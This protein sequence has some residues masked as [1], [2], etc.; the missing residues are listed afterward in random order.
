MVEFHQRPNALLWAA[1][2][3]MVAE[4]VRVATTS[5]RARLAAGTVLDR[6]R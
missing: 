6:R 4:T 1:V 3:Q 5:L 2:D